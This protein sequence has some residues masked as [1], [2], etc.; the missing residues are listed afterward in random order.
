MT[1]LYEPNPDFQKNA[2]IDSMKKYRELWHY[3]DEN[4]ENFWNNLAKEKIDWSKPYDKVLNTNKAPF[5]SWY[6]GGKL[7]VSNQCIDRHL[8]ER[9]NKTAIAWETESGATRNIT[10]KELSV[11]V[12][13][14]A[15]L[16]VDDLGVKK[17]DRVVIYMPMI[18]ETVFAMLAC[19]RI[20]A[21]HVVVF[22]GFSAEV[23]RE[24]IIDTG[25][26][27]IIT[28]D[29][30]FR[31]GKP[32]GLKAIVDEALNN[33]LAALCDKVLVIENNHQKISYKKGRDYS[34]PILIEHQSPILEPEQMDSE[35]TL[36]I[37]HTSGSTGKPKGVQHTTAG[38]ILW[39][40]YTTEIVFDIKEKDIFWCTADIGWITG[41]TYGVYG[42]LAAGSTIL[43]Y[44]GVPT[45]PDAGRWW[46]IIE[47]HHVTQFYTAPTAIRSLRKLGPNEPE[48]YDLSS[49]KV[50]GCVGEP[51][52]PEAWL[53]YYNVIGGGRCPIVDTWW[54]TETGGHMISPLPGATPT[55]PGSATL[56]L[57][58]INAEILDTNG[59]PSKPGEKGYLCITKPWP[60]MFRSIWRDDRRYI[61]GYFDI[62]QKKDSEYITYFSGDGAFYDEN[63][64]I[65]ITGRT[66]DVMNISGHRIG[67]AEIESAITS[68]ELIAEVAVVGRP[69]D[70]SGE[71]IVAYIVP[72]NIGRSDKSVIL[73]ELNIILSSEIGPVIKIGMLVV[74][75]GL[76]KTRSGKVLRRILRSIARGDDPTHDLSTIEDPT[77]VKII[78]D[79]FLD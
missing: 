63:G 67:S 30:S 9:G 64:Y 76:P 3:A 38:Y 2:H 68:H 56:P 60:S 77:I 57:P 48:K 52:N 26:K 21:V 42:P 46:K 10:Y 59:N 8:K 71:Q 50:L 18:P 34:Y 47:K 58:G 6:E 55:K 75:P 1:K 32:F 73:S 20:G 17:G 78:Q 19:A 27:I 44:E 7:N 70:I 53:W 37:L 72:K 29:G 11:S 23:L 65:V 61:N 22:G 4:A 12:N 31:H 39:A 33:P 35:D 16:L 49:L 66:D 13:K 5:Y 54:Q 62:I 69:D 45:F 51:I 74:V 40:Q 28:A 41:H 43:M 79:I 25:A 36:F 15:N 24:R 14:F